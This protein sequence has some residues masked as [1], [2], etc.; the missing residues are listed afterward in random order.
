MTTNPP[1]R[2]PIQFNSIPFKNLF[3]CLTIHQRLQWQTLD[4]RIHP[5]NSTQFHSKTCIDSYSETCPDDPLWK[6]HP[7]AN[8]ARPFSSLWKFLSTIG[9]LANWTCLERPSVRKDHYFL[10]AKEVAPGRFHCILKP[11][12][13]YSWCQAMPCETLVFRNLTVWSSLIIITEPF[14]M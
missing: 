11:S 5:F 1:A 2:P 9:F 12:M 6:D 10:I 4:D 14:Y 8:W 3:Q 7:T 13:L